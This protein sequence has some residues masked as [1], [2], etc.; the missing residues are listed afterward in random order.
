M[1][2]CTLFISEPCMY[3]PDILKIASNMRPKYFEMV[4]PKRCHVFC[5]VRLLAPCPTTNKNI[6][7]CSSTDTNLEGRSLL[8]PSNMPE[9]LTKQSRVMRVLLNM[10]SQCQFSHSVT[11]VLLNMHVLLNIRECLIYRLHHTLLLPCLFR[12]LPRTRRTLI[13]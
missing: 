11:R 10:R 8:V 4:D 1:L 9:N 12:L 6:M 3:S 7:S 5:E 13:P 2:G